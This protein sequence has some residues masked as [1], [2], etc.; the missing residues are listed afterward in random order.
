MKIS[1]KSAICALLILTILFSMS[2]WMLSGAHADETT[3]PTESSVS[4]PAPSSGAGELVSPGGDTTKPPV[5]E[6]NSGETPQS[7]STGTTP[8]ENPPAQEPPQSPEPSQTPE[9]SQPPEPPQPSMPDIEISINDLPDNV[10]PNKDFPMVL[11]IENKS[12][13]TSL[14]GIS[15]AL[16]TTSAI[17]I[18]K[19]NFSLKSIAAGETAKLKL[20]M[21]LSSLLEPQAQYIDVTMRFTYQEGGS[22]VQGSLVRRLVILPGIGGDGHEQDADGGEMIGSGNAYVPV[23]SPVPNVIIT[24]Y[25]F[26]ASKLTPGTDFHLSLEFFNTSAKTKIENMLLVV[27]PGEGIALRSSTNTFYFSE[28]QKGSRKLQEIPLTVLPTIK[29]TSQDVSLTFKYE[30]LNRRTRTTVTLTQKLSLP[31][32]QPDRFTVGAPSVPAAV[33]AGEETTLSLPFFNKGKT[34]VTNVSAVLDGDVSALS[35]ILNIGNYEAGKSGTIDFTVT[36]E[37]P[38]PLSFAIRVTYETAAGEEV[39]LNFPITMTVK[40]GASGGAGEDAMNLPVDD[41]AQNAGGKTIWIWILAG[42]AAIIP[43]VTISI[44]R[45]RKRKTASHVEEA[46]SWNDQ[47]NE[48]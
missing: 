44:R 37:Q 31:V 15:V 34:E 9:P 32:M 28:M 19:T 17:V 41:A 33:T 24:R 10:Q 14:T 45:A 26:G 18:D 5:N 35:K 23:D 11:S 36:P 1:V 12:V 22:T 13:T 2:G 8:S 30:Y 25:G 48:K 21:K 47:E 38:G 4:L 6:S 39:T 7:G 20:K 43:I 16:A 3:V 40:P 46:F 29:G 27:E 42:C